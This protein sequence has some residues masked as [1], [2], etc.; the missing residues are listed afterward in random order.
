MHTEKIDRPLIVFFYWHS[1]V[2]SRAL[3]SRCLFFLRLA[4]IL[5]PKQLGDNGA[6]EISGGFL[7]AV[8][9]PI[10]PA[11]TAVADRCIFQASAALHPCSLDDA[12]TLL[13]TYL[14]ATMCVFR[15]YSDE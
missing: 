2:R 6:A 13:N 1:Y 11:S 8:P 12:L 4:K 7:V 10:R 9:L 3:I 15:P 5:R 14:H